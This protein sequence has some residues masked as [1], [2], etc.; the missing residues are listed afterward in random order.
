ME[1]KKPN[2]QTGLIP[3][4]SESNVSSKPTKGFV[5]NKLFKERRY[6]ICILNIFEFL[7]K[8]DQTEIFS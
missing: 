7:K 6:L 8:E 3:K 1:K 5:G 4:N 2:D